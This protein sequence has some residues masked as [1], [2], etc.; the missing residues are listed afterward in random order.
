MGK[1]I[2]FAQV[3]KGVEAELFQ[4]DTPERSDKLLGKGQE[5]KLRNR[6]ALLLKEKLVCCPVCSSPTN[7]NVC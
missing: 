7:T 6:R 5:T 4:V 1:R 3:Q 2:Y